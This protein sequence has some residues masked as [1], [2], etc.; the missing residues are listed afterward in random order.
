[1]N[2]FLGFLMIFAVLGVLMAVIGLCIADYVLSSLGLYRLAKRR[3][4][5]KPWI[6][7]LPVVN[8]WTV[9]AVTD[10]YEL[11]CGFKRKWR[12]VLPLLTGIVLVAALLYNVFIAG[13]V[14]GMIENYQY[15][16]GEMEDVVGIVVALYAL[17]IVMLMSTTALMACQ[18]I[19]L[20]KIF[21]STVPERAVKYLLLSL[22]VPLAE[23]I[24]LFRCSDKGYEKEYVEENTE[25]VLQTEILLNENISG[26]IQQQDNSSDELY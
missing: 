6:A 24:C 3:G 22:L 19:C 16:Y 12:I 13:S 2:A 11:R 20:F 4:I 17:L 14:V 5:S 18:V 7:W 8:S 25:S 26:S 15:M 1:M 23:A 9:G 21:E 10:D